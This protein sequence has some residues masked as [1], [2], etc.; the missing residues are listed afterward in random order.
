MHEGAV[1]LPGWPPRCLG[2]PAAWLPGSLAG[3]FA[4]GLAGWL[5]GR[6]CLAARLLGCLAALLLGG[7]AAWLPV[8]LVCGLAGCRT[9]WLPGRL[10]SWWLRSKD[11]ATTTS[12]GKT[13]RRQEARPH[14]MPMVVA[15]SCPYHIHICTSAQASNH[16]VC[17]ATNHAHLP[18]TIDH[19]ITSPNLG[20]SL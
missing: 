2:C 6:A 8:R 7:L 18:M 13:T 12:P 10:V 16:P 1:R 19:W 4:A 15:W 14:D 17:M 11:K 20:E 3:R 5:A 9:G